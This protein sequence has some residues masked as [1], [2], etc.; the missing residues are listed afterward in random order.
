MRLKS[1]II[2]S[3]L[4]LT[5]LFAGGG[6]THHVIVRP[7]G[8][9]WS[10]G[11][12]DFGQLGTHGN[13]S[14]SAPMQI[15][16]GNHWV[17][18]SR[19][20]FHNI[21]L[22]KFGQVWTWG[23][24]DKGQ[25][26]LSHNNQKNYPIKVIGLP[27]IAKISAGAYHTVALSRSGN[28]FSWGKNSYGQLGDN[29]TISKNTPAIISLPNADDISC[30]NDHTL[31]LVSGNSIFAWGSNGYGQ[32]GDGSNS[33]S[34]IPLYVT[35]FEKIVSLK[36]GAFSS[37]AI[38]GGNILYAWGKN[39]DGIFANGQFQNLSIP[40]ALNPNIKDVDVGAKHSIIIS[41]DKFALGSGD[42]LNN[43]IGQGPVNKTNIPS[44]ISTM[45]K[46]RNVD[47]GE[48]HGLITSDNGEIYSLGM[49]KSGQLGQGFKNKSAG[50]KSIFG[51]MSAY[52]NQKSLLFK[53]DFEYVEIS[54][55]DHLSFGDST[56]DKPFSISAWVY[57]RD[58]SH[59]SILNKHTQSAISEY[60]F[61]IESS[62]GKLQLHLWDGTSSNSTTRIRA[63]S[64][65]NLYNY[66]N[67]WIHVAT[68]YDG[69][70][71]ETNIKLYVN[72]K[73]IPATYQNGG[74]YTAME[75]TNIPVRMGLQFGLGYYSDGL[76]DETSLWNK[77]LTQSEISTIYNNGE[78]NDLKAL[79]ASSNLVGWW[80]MGEKDIHP[81]LKN[82]ASANHYGTMKGMIKTDFTSTYPGFNLKTIVF[83]GIDDT[84]NL[85]PDFSFDSNDAFS[86]SLWVKTM[87]NGSFLS[88]L[89]PGNNYRGYDLNI[90]NNGQIK[91]SAIN[92]LATNQVKVETLSGFND[93]TEHF[94]TITYDGSS[95]ASGV[96]IFV[97]GEI[98]NTSTI[99]DN[100]AGTIS[101]NTQDLYIGT[102]NGS[103]WQYDGEIDE[104]GIWN[105]KLSTIEVNQ[106]FSANTHTNLNKYSF[107]DN[108][109]NW[110]RMGDN[111]SAPILFDQSISALT[112]TMTNMANNSIVLRQRKASFIYW[113]DKQNGGANDDHIVR[114]NIDATGNTY[115]FTS[116]GFNVQNFGSYLNVT[117][118]YFYWVD[119]QNG[120]ANDD[121]IKRANL[122]G[123]GNT[124]I[125]TSPGFAV[126]NFGS[127]LNVTDNYFYW[128][129]KQNGGAN[130]DYIKRANLDGSGNT[131]IFTSAGFAVQ[132]FG[133]HLTI[134][135]NNI[136]WVDKQNGGANDEY[137]K[138]AN[139]DG[140]G[141]TTIFTSPGF[142]VQNF[143]SYLN[144]T[145]N[146][147]YWVDK[148]NG[149]NSDD[150]IKRSNLDGSGNMTLFTSTGGA[151]QNFGS[152][153]NVTDTHLYWVQKANDGSSD[154]HLVR[155]NLDGSGNTII[156]VSPGFAVQDFGSHLFIKED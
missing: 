84:I 156:M 42:N 29:T 97:D 37:S 45:P 143:G 82:Y 49:N 48:Y 35:S 107:S 20:Q 9:M 15:G 25:L 139:L 36:A 63:L 136:Y 113:V 74:S 33:D 19:G 115:T 76:Q 38:W 28:V 39:V 146:Y 58:S 137:I 66:Q 87:G 125:F 147:I 135:G 110:L 131:T 123:S 7:D 6:L 111:D 53:G 62:T 138:R 8:N 142:A 101:D 151:Y 85:G 24:N 77:E 148:E 81:T 80:R 130:D 141:N 109:I 132:N 121:Y 64:S 21:A 71:N 52:Q 108:L 153:L 72:G 86:F 89:N 134:A 96:N 106:L 51:P 22:D 152:Y 75:N 144:V 154:D 116:P 12:N 65:D 126:Q 104:V 88:K 10:W 31:A 61:Q 150:Y 32:L 140:S 55:H 103:Q 155:A 119:K 149:G 98:E 90:K 41:G 27:P 93:G 44:I 11:A 50:L 105:K 92:T 30:G 114:A 112:A 16:S 95:L 83:D 47:T 133:S 124:T 120:G 70:G 46:W 129:D 14:S 99:S 43:Q 145:N 54:D 1:I 67:K 59:F 34:H 23:A 118:D 69:S 5:P 73:E 79:N 40:T 17:S 94:I 60:I 26:G 122:D 4:L 57:M 100:L 56:S 68:S 102:I 3:L 13:T 91:F 127:Y 2:C 18:V 78:P 117:D 128:V